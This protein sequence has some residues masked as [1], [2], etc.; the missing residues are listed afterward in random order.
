VEDHKALVAQEVASQNRPQLIVAEAFL[1]GKPDLAPGPDLNRVEPKIT[2]NHTRMKT[3]K[4]LLV[5]ANEPAVVGKQVTEEQHPNW[6]RN[7][8]GRDGKKISPLVMT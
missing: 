8:V 5:A 3:G 6:G 4:Q 2:V 7:N 1:G